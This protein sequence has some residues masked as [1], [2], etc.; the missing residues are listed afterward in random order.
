MVIAFIAMTNGN[1]L[2]AE[3]VKLF[4]HSVDYLLPCFVGKPAVGEGCG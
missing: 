1:E 4:E 3:E 2:V